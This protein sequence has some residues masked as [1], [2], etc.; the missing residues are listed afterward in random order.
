MAALSSIAARNR[1]ASRSSAPA[2]RVPWQFPERRRAI[3]RAASTTAPRS[4]RY[5][6]A[7]ASLAV[8]LPA[9]DAVDAGWWMG[10]ATDNGKG[11]TRHRAVGRSILL[12]RQ[13]AVV[14]DARARQLR[15]SRSCN[16]T[17]TIS[18]SPPAPATRWRPTASRAATGPATGSIPSTLRLCRAARRQRQCAVELQHDA[19]A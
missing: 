18:G 3:P 2:A 8:T 16:P 7:G 10:F 13:G 9:P 4:R 11:L 14:G 12:G 15:I 6:A 1:P 17:A 5:N 19:P